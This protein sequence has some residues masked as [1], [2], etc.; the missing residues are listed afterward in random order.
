M[1]TSLIQCECLLSKGMGDYWASTTTSAGASGGTTIIDTA[2]KAKFDD[3]MTDG[4][5]D[6]ITS[7]A[8]DEEERKI[9]KL[10]SDPGTLTTLA[11]GGQIAKSVTYRIHRLFSASDKRI[12]LI[13]AAKRSFAS[14]YKD[15]RDESIVSGN[16]LK[17]GSFEIWTDATDPTYWTNSTVSTTQTTTSLYYQ[18]GDTSCKLDTASGYIYQSISEWDDLKYLAGKTVTFTL[19]G[20]CD[21]ATALRIAIYDGKDTTYSSYHDGDSAWTEYD[22]PL[23]VTATISDNPT[24]IEFRIYLAS[25]SAVAYVDDARV[26][27]PKPPR[28]YIGNLGLA[29]NKPTEVLVEMSDYSTSQPWALI[30]GIR[31]DQANGYMYLP[32]TVS[33]NYRLRIL[34]KKYLDFYDSSKDVGTDWDDTIDIDSPQTEILVAGAAIY[35][36]SQKILPIGTTG[37]SKIWENALNY[38]RGELRERQRKFGMIPPSVTVGWGH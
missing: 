3:W 1:A 26:T 35:L 19:Q 15:V 9:T 12:A 6:M 38:W 28:L 16:W 2:L 31:Y 5:F 32:D 7:G 14:I 23:S 4:A 27:G 17:D 36:C 34:G 37:D 20:W 29:Q 24:A 21:T 22:D 13:Y 25:A 30:H 11:H 10:D 33:S 8:C 18:H